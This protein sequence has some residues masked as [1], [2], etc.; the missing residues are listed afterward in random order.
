MECLNNLITLDHTCVAGT[1][2]LTLQTI[3]ITEGLLAKV[4]NEDETPATM[5]ANVETRA[6]QVLVNDVVTHFADRII[7]RTMVDGRSFGIPDDE[8]VL[9]AGGAGERGG[10]VV[11]LGESG[12][13]QVL[14]LSGIG[15]WLP[16]A[17][18]V[19]I[20]VHDLSDGRLIETQD[21]TTVANE[22]TMG[23]ITFNLPARRR[24]TSYFIST[25]ATSFYTVDLT[26]NGGCN[27]CNHNGVMV[28]GV[29]VWAARLAAALPVRRPNL[30]SVSNT[31]GML[32]TVTVEC[33]HAALLC[34]IKE[35][36]ALPYL[37]KVGQLIMERAI[38]AFDRLN[39]Q[40]IDKEA[41]RVR[42]DAL[43]AEYSAAMTN[44]LS[45]MRLP[46]DPTCFVCNARTRTIVALP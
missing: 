6:K 39:S 33:D 28:G 17:G 10:I 37:Y 1:Q 11:E 25:Q 21:I 29:N 12:S 30:R 23:S 18:A 14:R 3:G 31:S 45:K 22:I 5:L 27:N 32:A 20:S 2:G 34:E 46:D 43:G 44:V 9:I 41:L 19:S 24:K 40:T 8:A 35:R 16:T 26:G 42:H 7:L 4:I 13:N 36:I 38:Y 15:M